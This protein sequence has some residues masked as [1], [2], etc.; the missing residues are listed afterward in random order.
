[1]STCSSTFACSLV[2]ISAFHNSRCLVHGQELVDLLKL[3]LGH[4]DRPIAD[5]R[6]GRH[7]PFSEV[8]TTT[9]QHGR[10]ITSGGTKKKSFLNA[11]SSAEHM[12]VTSTMRTNVAT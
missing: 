9:C 8:P 2:L 6:L 11:R 10:S 4:E 3:V 12:N 5:P 7:I 1:M